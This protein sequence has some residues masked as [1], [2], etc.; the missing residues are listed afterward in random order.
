MLLQSDVDLAV[1]SF[2]GVVEQLAGG[3]GAM[4]SMR[5]K[6]LY[7][8][9]YICVMRR[10]H[11]LSHSE[12]TLDSFCE[13]QHVVVSFTGR[14]E[15]QVNDALANLG[16]ERRIALTVN[17]FFTVGRVVARSDLIAVM[18]HHVVDPIGMGDVLI[19]RALP[20]ALPQVH[21]DMLWHERDTRNL[22]H[23]WLRDSLSAI[24]DADIVRAAAGPHGV[25]S[26]AA[27]YSGN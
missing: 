5:H 27:R 6:Q 19:T 1:G 7:S 4:S 14:A 23:K 8:G 9:E 12:L 2:P 26:A 15:D 13:A 11:P 3:Q 10:D 17:D 20:F 16:R 18:P 22:A 25:P 24:T 21:V